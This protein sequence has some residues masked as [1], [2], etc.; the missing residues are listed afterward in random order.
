MGSIQADQSISFQAMSGKLADFMEIVK[1]HPAV[2]NVVGFTGGGQRNSGNMFI[3]LKPLSE[4][5]ASADDVINQLRG[6]LAQEPGARLTMQSA[7]DIRVGGRGGGAQYQYTLQDDDLAE[8][9]EW[10]PKVYAAMQKLPELTDVNSDQQEGGLQ[11]SLT[12]NRDVIARLG[13]DVAVVNSTLNSA[14][15]QRQVST[16]YNPL[17]QYHVVMEVAPQYWQSPSDLAS[18][19]VMVSGT[20]VPLSAFS[21]YAPTKTPLSVNHQGQFAATTISFNLAPSVSLDTASQAIRQMFGT[22]GVPPSLQGS[23]QGTAKEFQESLNNQPML[24]LAALV[25]IYIVLG[26]LYESYIHPITILSTLPSAGVG[27]LLALL[28]FK[29]D[30]TIIALIGVILLIGIV[31][32]NAIMM[33]DFAIAAERDEGLDSKEAIFQACQLRFRPIMMTTM[34]ALLG[35]LPLALGAGNGSEFRQPL[36][37]SIVGGL[38]FS[39]LLTLYTTPV[40]YLYFDYMRL[41]WQRRHGHLKEAK[42]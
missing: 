33:V 42:A 18:A 5:T 19:Y 9:R 24:I 37:I 23:F 41:W 4:R 34:A 22:L 15:G 8:L 27:A 10:A 31:K 28:L 11:T 1:A 30:F 25:T 16:I 14:F 39:Q 40:V 6:K 32:K 20:Q 12:F 7:Q 21:T 36:G 29:I 35:A 13:I 17:N 3:S 2:A 38:I 26:V